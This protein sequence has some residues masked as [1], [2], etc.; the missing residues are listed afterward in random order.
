MYLCKPL[1]NTLGVRWEIRKQ[2]IYLFIYL[3]E[4]D[5]LKPKK[6]MSRET[7]ISVMLSLSSTYKSHGEIFFFFSMMKSL[8]VM[9]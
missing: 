8:E 7:V 6:E 9:I 4:I 5:Y 1:A 2:I 3:F